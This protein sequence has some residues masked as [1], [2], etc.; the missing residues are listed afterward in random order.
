MTKIHALSN[1]GLSSKGALLQALTRG[2][3]YGLEL[4]ERVKERTQ[5][6]VVL[7]QGTVYPAL[8]ALE[9]EGLVESYE[10][11]PLPERGGRPRVYYRLTA[12]GHRAAQEQREVTINLF[13]L[14][15]AASY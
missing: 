7:T 4:I 9:K 8:R 6:K 5:R 1:G 14:E 13:G 2:E 15:P 11:E 12:A 3:G 10:S